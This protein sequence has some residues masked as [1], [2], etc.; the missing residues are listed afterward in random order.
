MTKFA[1]SLSLIAMS[2]GLLVPQVA[3]CDDEGD[4][5]AVES[6]NGGSESSD[7]GELVPVPSDPEPSV[8]IGGSVNGH[9][10]QTGVHHPEWVHH[11]YLQ[12]RTG[13]DAEYTHYWNRY[14]AMQSPWHGYYKYHRW[15]R[16]TALIVP[17]TADNQV[18]WG[19]GVGSTNVVPI[20]HQFH[21]GN[22]GTYPASAWNRFRT[23]PYWP[24]HTD[25]FGV[26]P[27]R[28]PW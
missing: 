11:Q 15:G 18:K 27:V 16:P 24:S 4:A 2:F 14:H 12:S 7:N 17:P 3:R 19:W 5:A 25:Q 6:E 23:Q 20:Y 26:Y 28:G 22:P 13:A 8:G 9:G 10:I 1:Q 21:R